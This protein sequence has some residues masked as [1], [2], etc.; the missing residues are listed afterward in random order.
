MNVFVLNSGRCGSST[1][2]KACHHIRNYSA[3]HETLLSKTGKLRFSYP[4]NHI[5]ADNRLSW[6]LGRL[7]Q[8]YGDNAF[9]VHL[10]RNPQDTITSFA[11]RID[12]GILKAYEQGILMHEKHQLPAY[13]IARDYIE[14]VECNINHFLKDKSRTMT[15]SLETVKKDYSEFWTSINAQG[16]LGEALKEW[17]ITY[18]A[19]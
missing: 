5:E 14:T 7:E 2:I 18:N 10:K 13:D 12:F 9:Y 17:D 4:R 3:G 19:S 1:F 8:A 11:K 16:D 6:L 15:V